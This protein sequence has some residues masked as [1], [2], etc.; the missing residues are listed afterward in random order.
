MNPLKTLLAQAIA[1][2]LGHNAAQ[3]EHVR[4]AEAAL[5]TLKNNQY[6][7]TELPTVETDEWG[8]RIVKV[9]LSDQPLECGR[10]RLGQGTTGDMLTI[11]GVPFQLADKHAS[12]F[13][14]ALI[15]AGLDRAGTH[16][17]S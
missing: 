15:A 5:A 3:P 14:A 4:A 17:A 7:V 9:A 11:T 2:S 13:G 8:D 12:V 6:A 16:S 1:E 10:I